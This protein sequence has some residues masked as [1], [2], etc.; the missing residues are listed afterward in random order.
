MSLRFPTRPCRPPTPCLKR[1]RRS[2]FLWMLDWQVRC[3]SL[4]STSQG[5]VPNGSQTKRASPCPR[6]NQAATS[7][8]FKKRVARS[9]RKR[10]QTSSSR[11]KNFKRASILMI[12]IRTSGPRR[13][14]SARPGTSAHSAVP[15]I[16]RNLDQR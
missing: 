2:L 13:K 9:Y 7:P 4:F 10:I 11:P 15:R 12:S 3:T 5:A 8:T 6:A 14:E 16:G 1:Q